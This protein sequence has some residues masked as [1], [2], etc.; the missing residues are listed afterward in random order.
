[1]ESLVKVIVSGLDNAG[2][3]SI[4]TALDKKYDFAKDIVRLKPTIRVEYHK[5]NFLRSSCIFWDMG[6]QSQYREIYKQYQ[7]VYFD[8]TDLLIYVI[9][10]QD[11][12]RFKNSLEYLKAILTFFSESKMDVPVII[13]FHKYD[14][15]L[16]GNE[17]ILGNIDMLRENILEKYSNF[18]ILFQQTS[19]F[20]IISIVQ[21]V[22]YGLSVFDARF[23]EL[24]ELLEKYL[25]K[26][27][28]QALIIFDRNGIII[29]EYYNDIEPDVYVEL[30]ESIKE[31]LFLLKRMEEE[32]TYEYDHDISSSDH[33]LFSYL[34]RMKLDS[35]LFFV[36]VVT[37]ETHKDEFL[38]GF[39]QFLDELSDV[40]KELT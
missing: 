5:M 39:P 40:L 35:E 18:K 15:N 34:H 33:A 21:L 7:D 16:R 4:L 2:K 24:S 38:E 37:K 27:N 23:F 19:I 36:S 12:E 32:S 20:D 29:S 8:A 3:T 13:T 26:F 10:I 1:M 6:G 22:S 9:D 30:L 28:S 31:H 25:E 14:P 11:P 17:E